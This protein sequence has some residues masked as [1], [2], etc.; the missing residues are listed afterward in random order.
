MKTVRRGERWAWTPQQRP[1]EPLQRYRARQQAEPFDRINTSNRMLIQ[2]V[3]PVNLVNS[4]KKDSFSKAQFI[5][6]QR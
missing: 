3:N 1:P 6:P 4:V 5:A 2:P